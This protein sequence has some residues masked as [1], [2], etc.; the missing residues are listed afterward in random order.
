MVLLGILF[1]SGHAGSMDQERFIE[2]LA[3]LG[4]ATR[5][6]ARAVADPAISVRLVEIA[7]EVAL[8]VRAER[9]ISLSRSP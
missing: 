1:R 8:M 7:D 3:E 6:L 4:E 5:R 2:E 9:G